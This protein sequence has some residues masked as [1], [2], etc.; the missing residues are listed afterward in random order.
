MLMLLTQSLLIHIKLEKI[1]GLERLAHTVYTNMG[2]GRATYRLVPNHS[3]YIE[4]QI[5]AKI[6]TETDRYMQTYKLDKKEVQKSRAFD[7]F[8][9]LLFIS[10]YNLIKWSLRCFLCVFLLCHF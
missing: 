9:L 8:F 5:H 3:A 10:P 1:A 2:R 6:L 4:R 7:L